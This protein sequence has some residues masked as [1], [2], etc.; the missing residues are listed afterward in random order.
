MEILDDG[1]KIVRGNGSKP[2]I[3]NA[4]ALVQGFVQ[5]WIKY[6][7]AMQVQVASSK[8][9]GSGKP[10]SN[11]LQGYI[12]NGYFY[13]VSSNIVK[14]QSPTMGVLSSALAV[15]FSTATRIVD[16][17]VADGYVKRLQAPVD[18]RIV[19]VALTDRGMQLHKMIEQTTGEQVQH[20]L[21]CLSSEEQD[22]LF[23]LIGKVMAEL[24]KVT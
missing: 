6:E 8:T 22:Q 1:N 19:K 3:G 23:A 13:K 11:Q 21:S 24:A 18:R 20:L 9:N 15:P 16:G 5:L 14:H 7:A 4:I 17:M 10:A 12:T 2:S